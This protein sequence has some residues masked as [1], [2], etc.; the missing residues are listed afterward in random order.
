MSHSFFQA[1]PPQPINQHP[2]IDA[3]NL[4]LSGLCNYEVPVT[5]TPHS[6]QFIRYQNGRLQLL[7]P[8]FHSLGLK[9]KENE[10][11]YSVLIPIDPWLRAQLNIAEEFV[12]KNV[13]SDSSGVKP[14]YKPLWDGPMM[15]VRVA[16]WCQ[17]Y[18][19]LFGTPQYERIDDMKTIGRGLYSITIE[20][21]YIYIGPHKNGEHY[22]TTMRIVQVTHEPEAE[23]K[24]VEMP[25][26]TIPIKSAPGKGRR[27]KNGTSSQGNPSS[28]PAAA[29]KS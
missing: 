4:T 9:I 18:R 19:R 15:Y 5:K 11:G 8:Q 3:A 26:V 23:L 16:S 14:V 17:I 29:T 24:A 13:A 6:R 28:D 25:R 2:G 20:L 12:Q 10:N 7:T 27:K 21:P 22:S 1:S